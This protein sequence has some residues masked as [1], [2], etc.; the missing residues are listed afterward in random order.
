MKAASSE[1]LLSHKHFSTFH[2]LIL[3]A[4]RKCVHYLNFIFHSM[5]IDIQKKRI[6]TKLSIMFFSSLILQYQNT[7]DPLM[8]GP[9]KY[10]FWK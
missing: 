4:H 7:V 2:I 5:L 3:K 9:L 6:K 10:R 8:N 1:G